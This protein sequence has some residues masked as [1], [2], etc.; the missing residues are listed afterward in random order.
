MISVPI[1][2][3]NDWNFSEEIEDHLSGALR[4]AAGYRQAAAD[5]YRTARSSESYG[6]R[7]G[8]FHVATIW[9]EMARKLNG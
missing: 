3:I 6:A 7:E 5:S 8:F 9:A 2:A 4:S 1:Q